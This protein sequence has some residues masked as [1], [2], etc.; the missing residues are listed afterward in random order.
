MAILAD[1]L[2]NFHEIDQSKSQLY[3]DFINLDQRL[4][5]EEQYDGNE[6]NENRSKDDDVLAMQESNDEEDSGPINFYAD[7]LKVAENMKKFS[8][9]DFVA[10]ELLK[11]IESHFQNCLLQEKRKKWN[12]QKSQIFFKTKFSAMFKHYVVCKFPMY[13]L[14]AYNTLFCVQP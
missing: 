7:A 11:R 14:F 10:F 3:D 8:K 12:R 5:T 1:Y 13:V 4:I 2:R 6:E 9:E